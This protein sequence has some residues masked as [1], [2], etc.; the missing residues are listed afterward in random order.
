MRDNDD[1]G[2]ARCP[3]PDRRES[4]D[5]GLRRGLGAASAALNTAQQI[6]GAIEL[7]A[8]TT[9]VSHAYRSQS[10]EL[11]ATVQAQA[12][13]LTTDQVKHTSDLIPLIAQTAAST[14]GFLVG[15]GMLAVA[16]IVTRR[17]P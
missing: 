12:S 17:S 15:T 8:S 14:R 9:V 6:G 7:A 2:R 1:V 10:A 11:G 16:A 4:R 3:S 5:R 13:S